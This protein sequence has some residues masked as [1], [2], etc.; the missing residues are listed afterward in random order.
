LRIIVRAMKKKEKEKDDAEAQR[1]H[2]EKNSR[3]RRK[4]DLTQRARRLEHRVHRER[5]PG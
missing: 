2:R 1:I 5:A 3:C 4:T